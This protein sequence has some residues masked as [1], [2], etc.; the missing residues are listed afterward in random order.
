MTTYNHGFEPI[1][2]NTTAFTG[3]SSF[4]YEWG[5]PFE[6]WVALI[7]TGASPATYTWYDEFGVAKV[8]TVTQSQSYQDHHYV[9]KVTVA[10]DG[11][12]VTAQWADHHI[13]SSQLKV[14]GVG[15]QGRQQKYVTLSP[16]YTPTSG[17]PFKT[18]TPTIPVGFVYQLYETKVVLATDTTTGTRTAMILLDRSQ[19]SSTANQGPILCQTGAQT[20][21]SSTYVGFGAGVPAGYDDG[22]TTALLTNTEWTQQPILYPNDEFLIGIP[23]PPGADTVQGKVLGWIVPQ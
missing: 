9:R 10:G 16:V 15:G 11:S 2:L 13:D 20:G 8:Q 23:S 4:T 6:V 18:F 12:T 19:Y 21:T 14:T 5:Q 1:T 22:A 7:N 17:S 3:G